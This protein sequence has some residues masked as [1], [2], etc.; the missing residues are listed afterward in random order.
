MMMSNSEKY[1]GFTQH[2]AATIVRVN[3]DLP[4]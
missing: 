3:N 1:K 2:A 4:L